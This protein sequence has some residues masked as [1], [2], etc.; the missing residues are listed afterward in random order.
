MT[1]PYW[2]TVTRYDHTNIIGCSD[3][4]NKVYYAPVSEYCGHNK[5][6]ARRAA[7]EASEAHPED[8]VEIYN[9]Y[10]NETV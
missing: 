4:G 6:H 3:S 2:Y 1:Q 7:H 8:A 10:T 9:E 5:S